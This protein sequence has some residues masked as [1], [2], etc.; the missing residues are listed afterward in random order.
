MN[1]TY[2]ITCTGYDLCAHQPCVGRVANNMH[3]NRVCAIETA[4]RIAFEDASHIATNKVLPQPFSVS[5]NLDNKP[6]TTDDPINAATVMCV[7]R[8]G[9]VHVYSEYQ[10]WEVTER[11][12]THTN[13]LYRGF[14][15]EYNTQDDWYWIFL[16]DSER[17]YRWSGRSIEACCDIID[18]L[19]NEMLMEGM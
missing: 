7:N 16:N 10:V 12:N 14:R 9:N 4:Q 17:T 6:K 18:E 11:D 13:F 2:R 5:V 3:E 19:C 1:K 15:I 8:E